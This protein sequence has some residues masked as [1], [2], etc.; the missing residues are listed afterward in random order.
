MELFVYHACLYQYDALCL[1]TFL[2]LAFKVGLIEEM[3]SVVDPLSHSYLETCKRVIIRQTV[4]TQIRLLIMWRL[5]RVYIVCKQDFP[6]K[7]ERKRKIDP[8]PLK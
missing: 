8:T 6:S 5:I 3:K 2:L 4:Q 1:F 7:I